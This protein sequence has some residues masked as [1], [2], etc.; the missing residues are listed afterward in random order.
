M[1]N[2]NVTT[3]KEVIPQVTA[4]KLDVIITEN[5]YKV[6]DVRNPEGIEKQV[7]FFHFVLLLCFMTSDG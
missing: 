6:I 3:H 7:L 1:N 4:D 5:N 2:Q